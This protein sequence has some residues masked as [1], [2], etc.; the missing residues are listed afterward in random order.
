[1]G[2]SQE[3]KCIWRKCYNHT[4]LPFVLG[5]SRWNAIQKRKFKRRLIT[6]LSV[7]GDSQKP[8]RVRM[9]TVCCTAR[10]KIVAAVE[11]RCTRHL[12]AQTI[13]PTRFAVGSIVAPTKLYRNLR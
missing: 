9:C 13:M 12:E 4:V 11:L 3:V 2:V 8:G 10:V 6:P 5:K 7:A 1:M